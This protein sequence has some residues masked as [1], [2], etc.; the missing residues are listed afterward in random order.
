MVIKNAP[1]T[2]GGKPFP[3]PHW[4]TCPALKKE[5][6][7]IEAVGG[8]QDM[9]DYLKLNTQARTG[10]LKRE[11]E[12][13]KARALP[14]SPLA[15]L[16]ITGNRKPLKLKCLHAHAADFLAGE[17]NPVGRQVIERVPWPDGCRLCET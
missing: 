3:T 14:L 13:R 12:L 5:I 16:G 17:L 4:L 8:L 1:T 10:L 11:N 2:L 9:E 6:A 15:D 7:R